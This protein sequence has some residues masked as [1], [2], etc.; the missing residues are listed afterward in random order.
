[1][2]ALAAHVYP[3]AI[4]GTGVGTTVAVGRVG[5]ILA[6]YVGSWA[7]TAGGSSMYFSDVGGGDDGGVH[8]ARGRSTPHPAQCG[9]ISDG[10][11]SL[12]RNLGD[13]GRVSGGWHAAVDGLL[14][15]DLL[16][17]V[18]R[19]AALGTAALTCRRNLSQRPS[20]MSV[21]STSTCRIRSSRPPRLQI[22]PGGRAARLID[23]GRT[24]RRASKSTSKL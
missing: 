3:T 19:E 20:A 22:S 17:L 15:H 14:H 11:L 21:P 8:L 12:H 23:F 2:Y 10:C 18:R 4:R 9:V 13:L 6:S 1:M 24:S 16:D 7:L 5:N